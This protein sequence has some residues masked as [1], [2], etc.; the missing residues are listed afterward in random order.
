MAV[1]SGLLV[2]LAALLALGGCAD[3][4]GFMGANTSVSDTLV[5]DAGQAA[6]AE[7]ERSELMSMRDTLLARQAALEDKFAALEAQVSRVGER[8]SDTQRGV[9]DLADRVDA[10]ARTLDALE[11]GPAPAALSKRQQAMGETL[12]RLET[13]VIATLRG[14]LEAMAGRVAELEKVAEAEEAVVR[15]QAAEVLNALGQP[16][17]G[18]E[19]GGRYG[20]HLVSYRERGDVSSGWAELQRE[21]PDLFDGLTARVDSIR[22][23]DFGGQFHRLIVGPFA[24]PDGA[25]DLCARARARELFCEVQAFQGEA[26]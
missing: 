12:A 1:R 14:Q 6:R 21:Y 20:A 3:G 23:D 25:S 18:G 4:Q 11:A 26:I 10:M 5:A 15:E 22:L 16:V 7:I 19:G 8:L 13:D 2:S 9:K 17:A 24:T